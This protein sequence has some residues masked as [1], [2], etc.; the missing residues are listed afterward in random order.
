MRFSVNTQDAVNRIAAAEAVFGTQGA[1][2]VPDLEATNYLLCVGSNPMV[3]RWTMMATPNNPDLLKS[4]AKRG[5]KIVF[6]NPR[7]IEILER[8]DRRNPADQA[9]NRRVFFL[10]PCLRRSISLAAS[11]TMCLS[12]GRSMSMG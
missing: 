2:F 10:P 6:V 9:R 4:M 3:S 5:A 7:V 8:A 1:Q 12:A 11:I